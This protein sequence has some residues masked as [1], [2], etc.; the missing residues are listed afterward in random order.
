MHPLTDTLGSPE[1]TPLTHEDTVG[2]ISG[3]RRGHVHVPAH[4]QCGFK[5]RAL[6][7]MRR[8]S[9]RLK[10]NWLKRTGSVVQIRQRGDVAILCDGRAS[11]RLATPRPAQ[12]KNPARAG[13]EG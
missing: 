9:H 5:S 6:G 11:I 12:R 2:N 10:V 13:V 4:P 7:V 3:R 1:L 8:S